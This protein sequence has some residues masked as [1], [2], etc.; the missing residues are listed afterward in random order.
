MEP[1]IPSCCPQRT[2]SSL[3]FPKN[4]AKLS[5]LVSAEK[6]SDQI[7]PLLPFSGA[8]D[9]TD[10]QE[11]AKPL[12][13][14][15][16]LK[17]SW[18]VLPDGSCFVD[19]VLPAPTMDLV[20]HSTF[21]A[22]YFIELHNKT[23]ASGS[24]GQYSWPEGTPNYLGARIPLQHTG[25]NLDRWRY[26]LTG[27]NCPEIIQYLE[28]GFTLGLG[29]TELHSLRPALA[30][31]GSAYQYYA[32]LDKFFSDG[33]LKGGVTGPCGTVP[34]MPP[35][36]SP[37]MTAIKKPSSR[38]AVYDATFGQHSLNNAT[39]EDHYMGMK[40]CYTY[41]RVE[42]FQRLVI[43]S[44]RNCLLWKRD[45]SRYYLQIPLDPTEYKFTGAIWRGLFFFF[46]A[47]MF[48]LRHS[49]L[50]GQRITDSV[51]W[52]HH[53]LGLEYV[54]PDGAVC[55]KL[56][57]PDR[58]PAI[59]PDP[60]HGKQEPYNSVN[61]SDDMA[62]CESSKHK[63]DASFL[64]MGNLLAELG[65]VESKEK[66]CT[67]STVMTFLGV[68]FNTES[69]TMSV[70]PEK[71]EEIRS[72][73]AVWMKKT[74]AVRR[75]LQSIL[76]KLLWISKVVKHSRPFMGRL[77]QQLRDMKSLPDSKRVPL[78]PD[79]RKDLLWWSTYLREYNGVTA[80]VN[81]DDNQMPL[82][83][84]I[85]TSHKVC[86]GDAT[87]WGGGAWYGSSY[88][89]QQFPDFLRP[90]EIAVHI[91]EFWAVIASAWTWG[92]DWAGDCVYIFCDN[93]SVVDTIV[94]QKPRD[95]DY[96]FKL[97]APW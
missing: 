81:D 72:D 62:G 16:G 89:S 64:A 88:W 84:L 93:D 48:G 86:A 52:I 27:Y 60:E 41:P 51:T 94:H 9:I 96:R 97:T 38:R 56:L 46:V 22:A 8:E 44:G 68:S 76:G 11:P 28:H 1:G 91:K 58:H 55:G 32:W 63:A 65:L 74:T 12:L 5:K 50:Q 95:P 15:R 20:P 75:D 69:M 37:L 79:S 71:L 83:L 47:L 66:A 49:G 78:S 14:T 82:E 2:I 36:I 92:D 54:P 35:M 7:E 23:A 26:H 25:F 40:C 6:L 21:N 3:K 19:K 61:Y 13:K 42:D 67:P 73:L 34:F 17:N 24:R 59:S 18:F 45:L 77:L 80:I 43:K 31:H 85:T 87:L 29:D 53:N 39:P 70:P 57:V 4:S 30:N 33:L 10:F 90:T